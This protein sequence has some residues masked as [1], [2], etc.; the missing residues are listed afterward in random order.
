MGMNYLMGRMPLL[1]EICI[2]GFFVFVYTLQ[3]ANKAP[4]ILGKLPM[5]AIVEF[6]VWIVPL[7]LFISL[8]TN[9][10]KSDGFEDFFRRY[11]FSLVIFVPVLITWGD[12]EF[13]YWLSAVHLFSTVISIY[14]KPEIPQANYV[15]TS[16]FL[17]RLKLQPAQVI[18]FSF[19]GWI[20]LGALLLVLPV[21]ANPGKTIHFIDALF[22]STSATCVTGLSAISLPDEFSIFGQIIMLILSQVGGL[23][24]MTL[25][26]SM[27]IIMGKNLQMRE[28]VIMQDVLDTSGSEEL[29]HLIVNIIRYTFAIEFI[30][31]LVLTVGF[32]QEGFEIGQS[33]YFGF[34]HSIMAFC[35]SGY[36]LFN[37]NLEDFKFAPLINLTVAFLIIFGGIGFSVMQD[38]LQTIK[39]KRPLRSLSVHS[40]IVISMNI[41]LWGIGTAY[42][43]FG[44]FTHGLQEMSIW[45]RMQVA[46]FQS[47]TAR[48]AG[49]NTI[50]LN[51]FHPHS[52]YMLIIL[53]FIGASPGSTGGGV[54]VTTFAVLLQS[55]TATLKG[56]FDVEFF[57]R[58]ISPGTVVKSIAI[59]IISL[60]VVSGGLLI[61]MRVEPDKS[62]L[63]LAFETVS[64]FGT[65]GLSLGVTPFL[66]VL[67]KLTIITMMYLG[68]VG[69]LTLVF[70]VGSRVVLPSRVEYPEGKVLIG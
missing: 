65:V 49:F 29:L 14:E 62:F 69:P 64:A 43:F 47:V 22:M 16:S 6:A 35:N 59:F 54:K 67:G 41:A 12:I 51:S 21:S 70:A 40:K 3:K 53:M 18:L 34:Y 36:A 13:I 58:K 37:N 57:E 27:A 45:G 25:S 44:E 26:S 48:T 66:S 60:I 1:L 61:L 7:V 56:K 39:N 30:G 46:F 38:V 11:V 17:F 5:P 55:V 15:G 68:R 9:F 10:L 42:L 23:G 50:N 8:I 4:E 24:I 33:M 19:A 52:L 63:A 2:N 28:Q 31:A 32:Y 20:L